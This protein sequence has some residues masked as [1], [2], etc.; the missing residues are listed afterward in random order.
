MATK[1]SICGSEEYSELYS[2]MSCDRIVCDDCVKWVID[3]QN[4][5]DGN[6]FC[7]DCIKEAEEVV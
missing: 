5:F 2:C 7:T 1:C 6:Y 4:P 3:P